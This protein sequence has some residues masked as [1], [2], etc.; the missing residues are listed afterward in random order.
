VF[1]YAFRFEEWKWSK[2]ERIG[3]RK[4]EEMGKR[5]REKK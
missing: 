1:P 3:Y 5:G 2:K 4:G